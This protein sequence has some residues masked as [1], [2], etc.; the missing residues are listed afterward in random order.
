MSELVADSSV[1]ENTKPTVS[2]A[3]DPAADA[4]ALQSRKSKSKVKQLSVNVQAEE[5][6]DYQKP[7]L[8]P[9][10]LAPNHVKTAALL[11]LYASVH[12]RRRKT[13][14]CFSNRRLQLEGVWNSQRLPLENH[15]TSC[16][17]WW[18]GKEGC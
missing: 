14:V 15:F 4:N 3:S 12:L 1:N 16:P 8:S 9:R 13:T 11:Q 7:Q 18:A 5:V 2:D 17:G 6:D 10:W